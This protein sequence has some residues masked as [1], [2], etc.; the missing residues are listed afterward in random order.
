MVNLTLSGNTAPVIIFVQSGVSA[1]P[2]ESSTRT[3]NILFNASDTNGESDL[4]YST[5]QVIVTF[6]GE[7]QRTSSSCVNYE[8][9]SLVKAFN[10][11]VSMYYYDM[12]GDWTI[13]ATVRDLATSAAENNS[14]NFTFGQ[15]QAVRSNIDGITFGSVALGATAGASNDPLMLNNTG[16][17]NF[18]QVNLTAFSLIG[19][20]ISSQSIN[21]SSIYVNASS[22]NFGKR[23]VNGTMVNIP[24]ANLS[25]DRNGVD[26]NVSLYFWVSM[27]SSGLSNQVYASSRNWTISVFP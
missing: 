3:I 24:N 10:C 15:L 26:T 17:Q 11:T 13:N 25:R 2:L 16:N 7:Q 23:L 6:S 8:N 12:D 21:A 20:T 4:D 18:T 27:P 5:A 9:D 14:I 1:V 22:D 19:Q